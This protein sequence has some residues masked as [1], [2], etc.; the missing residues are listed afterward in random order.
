[1]GK[2]IY[3]EEL[4]METGDVN[5]EP[6]A[7]RD[8]FVKLGLE[9][10]SALK[11]HKAAGLW[12]RTQEHKRDWGNVSE[13]C[14]AEAARAEV[15]ADLF[16]FASELKKDLKVAATLHDYFKRR[17]KEITR[18]G[19]G[20]EGAFAEAEEESLRLLTEA[21]FSKRVI[22]LASGTGTVE[23]IKVETPR[24]LAKP[25]LSE[26]EIAYLVLH[27]I[28]DYTISDPLTMKPVWVTSAETLSDGTTINVFD[29]RMDDL[30]V[31]Y[32]ELKAEGFNDFQ[33][34]VGHQVEER[35]AQVL[36]ERTGLQVSPKEL[37]E[38]VEQEIKKRITKQ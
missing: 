21:G 17:E 32:P 11:L 28:D 18:E 2:M 25:Q 7:R 26:D 9:M 10:R 14:L 31:R 23:S 37:P 4:H 5:P 35:L 36:L 8:Y 19:G 6:S 15:F 29:K 38:T 30:D 34:N 12:E 13:H 22:Y 24:L 3:Y 27:Y 16:G 1:M 20:T 33:R